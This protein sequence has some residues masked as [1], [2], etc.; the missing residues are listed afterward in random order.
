MMQIDPVCRMKVRED[1]AFTAPCNGETYFFCSEGCR[2]RFLET[3]TCE[4]KTERYDFTIIGGGPAALTA[5]VYAVTLRMNTVLL[6]KN[7]GGQAIDST[8]I[9]NYMGFDFI[10]GPELVSK[11]ERQLLHTHYVDHRICDVE[12]IEPT[13]EGF[14]VRTDDRTMHTRAVL[15]ATGMTRRRLGIPGEEAFQRRGVFYGNVQDLSFVDGAD[16]AV[17]GG[18]NSALQM[19]ENL[20]PVA[21]R[22]HLISDTAFLADQT[23]IERVIRIRHCARYVGYRTLRFDGDDRLRSVTIRPR[24]REGETRLPVSGVFIAIG[25]V[26]NTS[27]VSDLVDLN[28]K[29]EI[30][31]EKNCATSHPGLFAAGDV[32]DAFGKRIIIA[33]GEGAKA[34]LAARQYLF[35]L[36]KKGAKEA[37]MAV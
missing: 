9:E 30:V 13:D 31:I 14:I 22:I 16:V 23:V 28:P 35:D 36:R 24:G 19:V 15:V 5:A 10:T 2:S 17:I 1:E 26:P 34:T 32:T 11:F 37:A 25:L 20:A 3:A 12:Q 33:A 27:I 4:V 6:A 8:K 18:G 21:R 7:L 29:G